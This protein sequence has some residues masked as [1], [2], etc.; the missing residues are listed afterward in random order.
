MKP[1]EFLHYLKQADTPWE[2]QERFLRKLD[3]FSAIF[4]EDTCR[5]INRWLIDDPLSAKKFKVKDEDLLSNTGIAI[6]MLASYGYTEGTELRIRT[7]GD[8]LISVSPNNKS[9]EWRTCIFLRV[10]LPYVATSDPIEWAPLA[11]V[12]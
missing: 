6:A 7:D 5:E 11:S 12:T 10:K 8:R 9:M 4:L 2:M 1:S 3:L